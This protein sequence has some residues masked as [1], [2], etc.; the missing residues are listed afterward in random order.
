MRHLLKLLL[1]V[2][3]AIAPT[4]NAT[5]AG[6]TA[7]RTPARSTTARKPVTHRPAARKTTTTDKRKKTESVNGYTTKG[8]N[9]VAP[10]KRR[11]AK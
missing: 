3:M 7:R 10:Y 4:T 2:F 11:P 1:L 6:K 8:G 9:R 5:A